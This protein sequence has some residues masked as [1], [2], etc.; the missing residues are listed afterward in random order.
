M[1]G[2]AAGAGV[3]DEDGS[4]IGRPRR[5]SS[6]LRVAG[7]VAGGLVL[8]ALAATWIERRPIVRDAVDRALAGRHVPASYRITAIGPFAQRLENVRIGDPAAPDLTAHTVEV[9][10]GY[11][12]AGP[13]VVAIRADGV[14]LAARVLGG[15]VSFGTIDR[16]LPA[17]SGNRPLA[18][19]DMAVDLTDSRVALATPA[20]AIGIA[21]DGAGRLSDG[22]RGH[23]TATAAR[24]ATGGCTLTA[25]VADLTVAIDA[26]RPRVSGPL[27]LAATECGGG[28]RLGAGRATLGMAFAA[29]LDRWHGAIDVDGFA[30][31]AGGIG[32]GALGGGVTIAGTRQRIEGKVALT[33]AGMTAP[34]AT[35][36]AL[37]LG[38]A[39]RYAAGASGLV[40]AGDLVAAHARADPALR[41]T[42]VADAAALDPTPLGPVTRRA[43]AALSALLADADATATLAFTAGGPAGTAAK[44]RRLVVAGRSGGVVRIDEGAGIGRSVREAG[45]RVDGHV[46]SG[47]GALPAIDAVLRQSHAGAAISGAVRLAPYAAGTARLALTPV[48]I[49]IGARGE[50]RFETVATIDGPLPGGRVDGLTV[51]IA[52][53]AGRGGIV[54]GEGCTPVGFDMVALSGVTL[55]PGVVRLCGVGGAPIVV[56]GGGG[57]VRAGAAIAGLHLAGRSGSA[58]LTLDART[59]TLTGAGLDAGGVAVRLGAGDAMTRL[60][61]DTLDRRF[62]GGAAG[63][64]SGAGGQIGSVPLVASGAA[65]DWRVAN[66]ALILGGAFTVADAAATARFKPLAAEGVALR[67]VAGRIDATATIRQPTSGARVADV[68]IVHDLASGRGGATL[69][70]PGLVF[71][72]KL[73][74][75]MLTPVTLGVI[76]NVAGTIR[77]AGRIDWSPQGVTSSGDFATDRV[78]LAAAFGP[79]TGIAGKIHFSDLLGLATPPHQRA[80]IA[81]INPGVAVDDGT[82]DF[83]LL[84]LQRVAVERA[85]WPFAGGT[86]TLAPSILAFDAASE[87]HLT[88][89]LDRLDAAIF[90]QQLDLPNIAA[91]GTFDGEL[92]IIFDD[93]G[94][95]IAGGHIAAR[96]PGG[97]IAYVGDLTTAQLGTMGHLAFDALKAIRYSA[98]EIGLDGRLEGEI[99]SHVGFQGIRQATPDASYAARL[100]H[101]LP[102]RFNIALRAPFRSLIG[103]AQSYVDPSLL[104]KGGL[105]V[106]G[107][108]IDVAPTPAAPAPIQPPESEPVR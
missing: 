46:A 97:T 2:A 96:P 60:D 89:R 65:G 7:G 5:D 106:P 25:P 76:A 81:E 24:L 1:G 93:K 104:L 63:H 52:G 56:A 47:G 71:D 67:L 66:G 4:E 38:G 82:V 21:I 91:T 33:V 54:V 53:H 73:Q 15:R 40:Y 6:R 77:G 62:A 92:P 84:P 19:P 98:L 86:L 36:Q 59:L 26:H 11:G 50:T 17:A 108:T 72:K 55:S 80:T 34:G 13:H 42:I 74:P 90:V 44:L 28:L 99:V 39:Y 95:R 22:F 14:R 70:V 10:L 58:P 43:G 27:T 48:R 37:R 75:E 102:F 107:D 9:T 16:L 101:N 64:F 3:A 31:R 49:A 57:G 35:A 83:Q 94:G 68:A 20:G 12:L 100:I 87:R 69:G 51:P 45:W 8:I 41:R 30:G 85:R 105:P 103:T 79:V 23:V 61:I 29:A 88:F 18:L 32:F 78:D